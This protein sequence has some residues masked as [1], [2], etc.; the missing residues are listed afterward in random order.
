[1]GVPILHSLSSLE[2]HLVSSVRAKVFLDI[3]LYTKDKDIRIYIKDY[4]LDIDN[5]KLC[6]RPGT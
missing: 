5:D 1:M 3:P 2:F 4:S 6:C